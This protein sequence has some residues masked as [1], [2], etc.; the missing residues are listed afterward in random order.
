ME[1][2]DKCLLQWSYLSY[3]KSTKNDDDYVLIHDGVRP[4]IDGE[5]FSKNIEA[6][7]NAGQ[8]IRLATGYRNWFIQVDEADV[9]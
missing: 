7:K 6:A 9:Y 5:S 3:R 2:L 1:R 8:L 4:L